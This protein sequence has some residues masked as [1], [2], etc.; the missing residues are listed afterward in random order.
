M[1]DTVANSQQTSGLESQSVGSLFEGMPVTRAHW[2]AGLVLF[3]TFAIEA[4]EMMI[5]IF[6]AGAIGAEFELETAEVGALISA[7]FLGMIPGALLWGKL[8]GTLGR[9]NSLLL[10]IGLYAIFPIISVFS[11]SYEVLWW[12]RF[13]AG[14]VLAGALVVTF[15]L[16][17]ELL[18]V[19]A[20]GKAAVYLS[21]GWPVGV[22]VAIGVTTLLADAG[23]RWTLGA[24]AVSVLWV[25]MILRFVPESA[26]WLAERGRTDEADA[27]IARLSRGAVQSKSHQ[28]AGHDGS[29]M[30]FR[31]IFAG[32]NL[33]LTVLSTIVNFCFA[34]GYWGMTTW[35]PSLLAERGLSTPQGLGFIALSTLFMFPG[36]I[37][38]SFLTGRFGRKRV[39]AS[40]V[41]L[42]TVSGF[43]FAYSANLPQ[44]YFWSFALSF[45]NLGA[46]GVWNTWLGEIYATNAR[47]AGVAWGVML[48]R[49]ANAVAPIAIGAVLAGGS[50]VQTVS[51]ISLFL[52]ITFVA[53]V[54][55]PETEGKQLA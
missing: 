19:K 50:F 28:T 46:W 53:A 33:W 8:A 13:F 9:K 55:L 4:W 32:P 48:Q 41:A 2:M 24:S 31:Q 17:T 23:W 10:S 5:I 3:V 36:Y 1:T 14:V 30:L 21:A 7:I 20:R 6:S 16:F 25:L 47:G 34:W 37:S 35:L 29:R 18:P 39:M 42:A 38:A 51:F 40:F 12:T 22:L 49:I 15:P 27:V 44:L 52:A 54:F 11:P 43:G 45:F 26:Y